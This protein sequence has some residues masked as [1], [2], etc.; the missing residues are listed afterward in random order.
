MLDYTVYSAPVDD[1]T[2]WRKEG[3]IPVTFLKTLE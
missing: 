2:D 1:L 3:V